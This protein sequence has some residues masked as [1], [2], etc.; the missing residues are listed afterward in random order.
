MKALSLF[1]LTSAGL[2]VSA[3]GGLA[4]PPAGLPLGPPASLTMGPPAGVTMGPPASVTLGPPAA[5]P[6]HIP[7][8][9]PLGQPATLPQGDAAS[10]GDS[11]GATVGASARANAGAD[12][13]VSTDS[14]IE[15]AASLLGN[16]NAAHASEQGMANAAAGSIVGEIA[17]YKSA[18]SAALAETGDAQTADITAAREQLALDS[19]KQ[20]TPDAASQLDSLLGIS[21]ADPSLGTTP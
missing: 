1:A 3:S 5:A 10:S 12:A 16:L 21:G 8:G 19:N 20:L 13:G 7:D 17:A 9:V 15:N 14:G 2:L 11:I 4:A 6:A 18:M